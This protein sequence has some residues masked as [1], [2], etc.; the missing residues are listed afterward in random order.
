MLLFSKGMRMLQGMR[1]L[2]KYGKAWAFL[3]KEF[4]TFQKKT[5]GGGLPE[6]QVHADRIQR[7][8][9]TPEKRSAAKAASQDALAENTLRFGMMSLYNTTRQKRE[10]MLH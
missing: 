7:C 5:I 3:K 6:Q 8:L 4:F 10:N 2:Q 9:L 1:K